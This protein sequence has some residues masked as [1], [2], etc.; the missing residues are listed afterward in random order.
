MKPP[1]F[2]AVFDRRKHGASQQRQTVEVLMVGANRLGDE[3]FRIAAEFAY[4]ALTF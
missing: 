3:I 1:R 2:A 4:Q